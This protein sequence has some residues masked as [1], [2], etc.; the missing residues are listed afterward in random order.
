MKPSADEEARGLRAYEQARAYERLRTWRLPVM[1]ILFALLPWA[2]GVLS[3]ATGHFTMAWINFGAAAFV[4]WLV[5]FQWRQLRARHGRNLRLL[6]QLESQY[7]EQLPWVQVEKHFADLE[8][9]KREIEQD[10]TSGP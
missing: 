9:L 4:T 6:G 8:K 10:G 5:Q 1:F 2:S 3:W 7:G